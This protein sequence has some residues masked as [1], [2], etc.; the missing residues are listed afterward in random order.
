MRKRKALT[1]MFVCL[2]L[3]VP[4]TYWVAQSAQE[5]KTEKAEAEEEVVICFLCD[6]AGMPMYLKDTIKVTYKDRAYYVCNKREE[7]QF[8]KNPGK[9]IFAID[10]ISGNKINKHD[11]VIYKHNEVAYFFE[12]VANR[13]K[14]KAKPDKY[15]E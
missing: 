12:T 3:L 15:V 9:W 8:K 11:A 6:A 2:G 5:T 4:A 7:M 14:F 13:D 1:L 10:P